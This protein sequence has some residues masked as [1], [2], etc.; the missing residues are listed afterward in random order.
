MDARTGRD[1]RCSKPESAPYQWFLYY[2]DSNQAIRDLNN[3]LGS[4]EPFARNLIVGEIEATFELAAKGGLWK[5]GNRSKSRIEPV[6]KDPE[7]YE[8]RQKAHTKPL[9]FYHGEPA[10]RPKLLVSLH[11]HIKTSS[12]DQ[13]VQIDFAA[14]RYRRQLSE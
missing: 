9:R 1:S 13:Q 11:K 3:W 2:E 10:S 7:M 14:E 6:R 12:A 5:A 8:I 4:L